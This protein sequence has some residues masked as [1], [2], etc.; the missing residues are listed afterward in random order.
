MREPSSQ[1]SYPGKR[2]SANRLLSSRST[3]RAS[4]L[5]MSRLGVGGVSTSWTRG[6]S[7]WVPPN[8]GP[9]NGHFT[10]AASAPMPRACH[11][12]SAAIEG[13]DRA[14]GIVGV[15][16]VAAGIAGERHF[17]AP[18]RQP[19]QV[20]S[21]AGE[22]ALRVLALDAQDRQAVRLELDS[23]AEDR[24]IEPEARIDRRQG[25]RDSLL[26]I[27]DPQALERPAGD[28]DVAVGADPLGVD[29][30]CAGGRRCVMS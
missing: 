21:R 29:R 30:R 25:D 28:R 10:S 20:P 14:G 11:P 2:L 27:V 24:R 3:D 18:V 16:D 1:R 5:G 9:T 12:S 8:S 17:L 6:V 15:V 19:A 7:R 23:P 26:D 13:H 4:S 22:G